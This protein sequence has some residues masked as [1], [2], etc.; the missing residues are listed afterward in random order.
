MEVASPAAWR[1]EDRRSQQSQP[2]NDEER[3]NRERLNKEPHPRRW[4]EKGHDHSRADR[5]LVRES[6]SYAS[7]SHESP[8]L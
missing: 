4:S 6:T 5:F 7:G 8:K 2:E 1:Q 3:K